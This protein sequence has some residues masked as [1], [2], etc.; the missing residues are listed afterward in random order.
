[1]DLTDV[2]KNVFFGEDVYYDLNTRNE[3]VLQE[4]ESEN[5][6]IEEE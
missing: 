5:E 4:M 6:A 2:R 3:I 1:M